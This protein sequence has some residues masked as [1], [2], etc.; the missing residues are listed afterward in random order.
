ME[1]VNITV[2]RDDIKDPEYILQKNEIK[3]NRN[4]LID[5]RIDDII[6]IHCKR[7]VAGFP[8]RL[9]LGGQKPEEEGWDTLHDMRLGDTIAIPLKINI[10]FPS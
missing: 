9:Q 3:I 4:I 7:G 10:S 6:V 8:I 1:P 5:N 2:S